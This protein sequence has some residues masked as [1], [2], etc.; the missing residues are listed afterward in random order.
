MTEALEFVPKDVQ[1]AMVDMYAV[2]IHDEIFGGR[3]RG[4]HDTIRAYLM[5]VAGRNIEM[6]SRADRAQALLRECFEMR[7]SWPG[8]AYTDELESSITLFLAEKS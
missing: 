1:L 2:A 6:Q 3:V 5:K 4:W 7:D 8:I